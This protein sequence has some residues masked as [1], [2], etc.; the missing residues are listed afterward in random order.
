MTAVLGLSVTY[1]RPLD[2]RV[3]SEEYQRRRQV[4][5]PFVIGGPVRCKDYSVL[6]QRRSSKVDLPDVRLRVA[7]HVPLNELT[8]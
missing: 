4:P 2:P 5:V 8:T 1:E 7:T 3:V 6:P